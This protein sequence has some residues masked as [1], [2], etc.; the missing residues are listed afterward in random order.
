MWCGFV[1]GL[2]VPFVAVRLCPSARVHSRSSRG[3]GGPVCA[4]PCL[5]CDG[6][7]GRGSAVAVNVGTACNLSSTRRVCHLCNFLGRIFDKRLRQVEENGTL[8]ALV[9]RKILK[10]GHT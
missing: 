5:G 7:V 1:G 2:A 9:Q 10:M 8:S 3:L 4:I 6:V